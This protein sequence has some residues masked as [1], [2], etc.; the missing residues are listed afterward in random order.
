MTIHRQRACAL[1]RVSSEEQ[2]KGGY[3]LEF[4]E[5]DIRAFCARNKMELVK[6][7]RDEGYSGATADRPGFAE[8]MQCARDRRFE[9]LVVWKLDRLFR[10]T[11]L[12]LQTVDEL[13]AFNIEVRSVQETFTHD[14][15]GRF[16]LTIFAA[17]AEKERKDITMRMQ[18]GRLAAA[19]QGIW[20]GGGGTPPFGYRFNAK[21]KRLVLDEQEA[22]IVRDLYRWL[23]EEKLSLYKIQSRLNELRVPTKYDR[24]G[25]TKPS[26]STGWWGK[27]TVGRIV[28]NEI[29]CGT[30]TFRKYERV[31]T[32][33]KRRNLRP[34]SDWITIK[35]PVII[36]K[37][38]FQKAQEQIR[39]NAAKSPRRTKELYLLRGLL[40]C[41]QDGRRM[42]AATR[43]A[44][45]G[46]ECK[47]YFCPGTRK[48]FAANRCPSR[49]VSESRMAPPVWE[50]LAQLLTDPALALKEI[51]D[52]REKS[53][54]SVDLTQK[55]KVL[56]TQ[57]RKIEDRKT[58]LV[59]LYLGGAVDKAFFQTEHLHLRQEID[60]IARE[61]DHLRNL[62][63]TEDEVATRTRTLQDLFEQYKDKLQNASAEAKREILSTFVK[64][65]VVRGEE[66]EMQITLPRPDRFAGQSP[67]PL[68]R[69]GTLSVFLRTRLIPVGELF[70]RLKIH[71]NFTH[72]P[73]RAQTAIL[74]NEASEMQ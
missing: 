54:R 64:S 70:R 62:I 23:V 30:F 37:E 45:R 60:H 48:S 42:Q 63:I 65:V 39:V 68:S 8:M 7:F 59:E 13:T 15:N 16:L 12:T 25:R 4:Q 29:Y 74:L 55:A 28:S 41:G 43:P 35:T 32:V 14:S 26:G 71:K 6:V 44:D 24:L 73:P 61:L 31:D 21:T 58:R 47:Y 51:K 67:H 11:K 10:D 66:L 34:Q 56:N 38:V 53:I 1:V 57:K 17:G 36:S 49:S 3:G 2:A 20:I 50:K 9:I 52:Y 19:K 72:R 69:K 27:R 46:R 5:Q 18:A 33:H 40:V 22:R